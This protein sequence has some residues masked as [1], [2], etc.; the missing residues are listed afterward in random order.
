[1]VLIF[2]LHIYKFFFLHL[3]NY[4]LYTQTNNDTYNKI[5]NLEVRPKTKDIIMSLVGFH[6][7]LFTKYRVTYFLK[8]LNSKCSVIFR[9]QKLRNP[10]A[11]IFGWVGI[12]K[13]KYVI[14]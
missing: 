11:G 9:T 3:Q 7:S 12:K 8:K 4:Y 13:K 2:N 1:M 10:L 6:A 14:Y 5:L